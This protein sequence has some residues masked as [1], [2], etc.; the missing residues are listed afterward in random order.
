MSAVPLSG[1]PDLPDAATPVAAGDRPEEPD[2]THPSARGIRRS[3]RGPMTAV[4]LMRMGALQRTGRALAPVIGALVVLAVL[5]GGG[6][7]RPAEAY[8]VSAVLLFPV[9]AWQTK[10]L[11]DVEPDV[12]RRLALVALR[13][14][15]REVLAG[16]IAAALSTVPVIVAALVMPWLF[17]ALTLDH[18]GPGFV[19]SLLLGAWVHALVVLP[20]VALGA[21]CSRVVAGNA[22]RAVTLLAAGV[23]VLLLLGLK[24]SPVPWLAPPLL[25]SARTLTADHLDYLRLGPLTGWALLWSA[26]VLAGYGWMRRTRA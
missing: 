11:L 2:G 15:R 26:V 22:G 4:I 21:W 20:A 5:Y 3:R 12:Q 13:S 10:I 1:T 7:A 19:P 9:F 16:L 24:S 25:T 23:V 6:Q 18:G 14:R 17:G 8:G